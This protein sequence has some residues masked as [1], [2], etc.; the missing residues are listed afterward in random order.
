[1]VENAILKIGR[2][3]RMKI[4]SVFTTGSSGVV[5]WDLVDV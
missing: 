2:L 4:G 5:L 1:M 3:L